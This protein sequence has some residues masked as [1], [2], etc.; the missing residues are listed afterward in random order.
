MFLR[1]QSY[2]FDVNAHAG[3]PLGVKR[4][5]N[6]IKVFEE[7]EISKKKMKNGTIAKKV[8]KKV[9]NPKNMHED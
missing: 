8:R 1:S 2:D 7:P 9:E 4:L 3:A 5:L 6:F